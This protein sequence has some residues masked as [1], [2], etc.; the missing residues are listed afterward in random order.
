MKKSLLLIA[1]M[2]MAASSYAD[3]QVAYSW[4]S[5][6]GTVIE[7][8]GT[9]AY[10]NGDGDRLNYI[11]GSY[12]TVC[13]NGKKGNLNDEAASANAGHM[14]ITLDEAL[15]E[16]DK[17]SMTGFRN[18]NADGKKATVY[19]L[20]EN[21][22]EFAGVEGGMFWTNICADDNNPDYDNDGAEPSTYTWTVPAAEA[23][24]K[25]ITLT[26]NDAGT[27]LFFTE[28]KIETEAAAAAPNLQ[29]TSPQANTK[30]TEIPDNI[31][32]MFDAEV[33]G[34]DAA[35]IQAGY[36]DPIMLEADKIS[37]L[38]GNS[39]YLNVADIKGQIPA[40]YVTVYV[41]LAGVEVPYETTFELGAELT[42]ASS[43]FT[44][45][46][47][48]VCFSDNIDFVEGAETTCN[49]L[50]ADDLTAAVVATVATLSLS[51]DD[52]TAVV[53]E[54]ESALQAGDYLLNI[55]AAT[56]TSVTGEE[57]VGGTIPFTVEATVAISNVTV[58]DGKAMYNLFGQRTQVRQGFVIN[59]AKVELAR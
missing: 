27:N 8:G 59:N 48:T 45:N 12:W 35:A 36:D 3:T 13:L 42:V 19:M 53:V 32:F 41:Q 44:A 38:D 17:I 14:V 20:F 31:I 2:A 1:A 11:Q 26:R 57:Y 29:M 51:D 6:E 33:S 55:P 30:V 16:G 21:G 46:G 37:V 47:G 52:Y 34:V 24:A 22:T 54:F 49:V 18:K 10:V 25:T 39:V 50:K 56:I 9:I 4:S 15:K 43:E 23:G 5:P 7:Q 58:K 28:I 40:G